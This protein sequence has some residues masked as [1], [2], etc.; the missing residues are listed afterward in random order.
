MPARPHEPRD[1]AATGAPGAI[2]LEVSP[3]EFAAAARLTAELSCSHVLAQV[4]VRRGLGDPDAARRFL[5]AGVAHPLSAWPGLTRTAW[6]VLEH[7][8][9]GSRITVHGDYD[10]DGV[11]STAILVRARRTRGG[12]VEWSLPSRIDDGYGLARATV[13]RL[14]A[15]GTRLLITVDCAVTAVEEVAA[16]RAAGLD[17]LVTDPHAPRPEGALRAAPIVPPR[18]GGSPCA[19]LCAAAVAH[20]LAQ[21]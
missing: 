9:R 13:E 15:R 12:D 6:R 14:A 7:V 5:E 19:D 10:V 16:A 17:V 18:L 11:C 1:S 8:E 21:A 20:K 4:L 3:Y 2:R